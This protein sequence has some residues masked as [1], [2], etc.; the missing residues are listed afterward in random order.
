MEDDDGGGWEA[1]G[2]GE[3]VCKQLIL[4]AYVDGTLCV[5]VCGLLLLLLEICV[6][7]LVGYYCCCYCWRC[8][9]WRFISVCFSRFV[10][11]LLS[12]L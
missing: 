11:L 6:L 10:V 8:A 5:V 3:K 1:G 2:R 7:L 12:V 9:C 4:I